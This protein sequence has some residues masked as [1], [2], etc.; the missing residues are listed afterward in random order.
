[1]HAFVY[2]IVHRPTLKTYVG[3]SIDP[4]ERFERHTR[5]HTK[6]GNAL[7]KHGRDEFELQVLEEFST[8][9]E[10]YAREAQ[11]IAL[12]A[13]D[14]HRFGYNIAA[15]GRG[16]NRR[17]GFKQTPEWIEKRAN[18]KRGKKHT[19]QGI[20]NLRKAGLK[21]RKTTQ[22]Q[23]DEIQTL[24]ESGVP[25]LEIAARLNVSSGIVRRVCREGKP[26][27]RPGG[28][29]PKGSVHPIIMSSHEDDKT[30]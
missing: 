24:Y 16:P 1:M 10:A 21:R 2:F 12:F 11:L 18:A 25:Q 27:R 20:E 23:R 15:G 22:E 29:H 4:L 5:A 7:R 14:D 9:A 3:K 13:L 28:Y 6:I 26:K 30:R 19:T 17:A 8:E